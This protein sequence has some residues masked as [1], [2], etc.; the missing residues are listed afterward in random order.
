MQVSSVRILK[1]RS[2]HRY[3][4]AAGK[5]R[6]IRAPEDRSEFEKGA[7]CCK[8]ALEKVAAWKS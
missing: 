6:L 4:N 5:K 1:W 8:K 2:V 7:S 3:K